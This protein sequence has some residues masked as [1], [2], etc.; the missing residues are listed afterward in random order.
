MRTTLRSLA[1]VALVAAALC[2]A[3]AS[4]ADLDALKD[5]TP[6]ERAKAQTAMMKGKLGL[7]DAEVAKVGPINMKYAEKM[8]PIIKGDKLPLMKM[9]DMREVEGQKE[10]ELKG[11][12]T[13][14][15]LTKFEASKEEMMEKLADQIRA[16][17]AK[18]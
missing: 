16:D 4:A 8:E 3:S 9:K 18:K 15:Q 13:A 1:R 2:A 12:L 10:A 5:T 11:I 6:A 7:T 17:R 14:D